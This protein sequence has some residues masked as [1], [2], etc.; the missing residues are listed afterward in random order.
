MQAYIINKIMY[1]QQFQIFFSDDNTSVNKL[2]EVVV[3]IILNSECAT[4]YEDVFTITPNMIC[5]LTPDK[6]ACQVNRLCYQ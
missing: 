2:Q 4:L 6:D 1:N 5:T 3:D